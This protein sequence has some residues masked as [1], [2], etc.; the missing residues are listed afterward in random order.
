MK[1][2]KLTCLCLFLVCVFLACDDNQ[3]AQQADII[4]GEPS[5]PNEIKDGFYKG[6]VVPLGYW[7][8]TDI[9]KD[10][11]VD[12]LDTDL[13]D[14]AYHIFK[15]G[16]YAV[17]LGEN[18]G[19]GP[20]RGNDAEYQMLLDRVRGYNE[21]VMNIPKYDVNG[22]GIIDLDDFELV[23]N[24]FYYAEGYDFG[25]GY[26]ATQDSPK[27]LK[28]PED[29][30]LF[31][32]YKNG[33]RRATKIFTDNPKEIIGDYILYDTH[34]QAIDDIIKPMFAGVDI[35]T[36]GPNPFK[37]PVSIHFSS[38]VEGEMF[39]EKVFVGDYARES[40]PRIN[41]YTIFFRFGRRIFLIDSG[42]A[43]YNYIY[44]VSASP[45]L[46]FEAHTKK[47]IHRDPCKFAGN[48]NWIHELGI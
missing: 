21:V 41:N 32:E 11:V 35:S 19:V 13:I 9:N 22:N 2:S 46:D 26:W 33:K 18:G 10:G 43:Y 15:G 7:G 34:Q 1:E 28:V 47:S 12:K 20:Y 25:E 48:F 16:I 36:C 31:I 24:S 44:S 6:G 14:D 45:I 42:N 38:Q 5:E 8:R 23:Y 3:I 27:S 17:S 40:D 30:D 4:L 37:E 29:L 39:L